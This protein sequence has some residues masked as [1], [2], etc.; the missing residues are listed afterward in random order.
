MTDNRSRILLN[1]EI[2]EAR[3]ER[4]NKNFIQTVVSILSVVIVFT[5]LCTVASLM[6]NKR[7]SAEKNIHQSVNVVYEEVGENEDYRF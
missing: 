1:C 6:S 2:E 5:L 7:N 4:M 3:P